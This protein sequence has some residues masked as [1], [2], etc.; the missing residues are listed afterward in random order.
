MNRIFQRTSLALAMGAAMAVTHAQA[1]Q[2]DPEERVE[3]G[4]LNQ[5]LYQQG[6][7]RGEN[8]LGAEVFG[9]T[10][11]EIGNVKNVIVSEQNRIVSVIAEVGGFWDMGDTHISVPW[12]K[13]EVTADGVRMPVNE[14]NA[15]DYNLFEGESP[16][17]KQV[18]DQTVEL[19]E[20]DVTAGQRTWKLTELL[21]DYANLQGGAGY[22]YV[23]D[24]LFS[25][26]GEV[27]AV[28]V[29]AANGGPNVRGPYAYPFYGYERGWSPGASSYEVPYSLEDVKKVPQFKEEDYSGLWE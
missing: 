28:I 21:N 8:L 4:E 29:N 18:L 26:Q 14:D 1:Q 20:E 24:V 11:E 5:Q 12:E 10:G 9:E 6:G 13:V 19:G 15:E 27:Q 16:V 25:K 7:I 2:N 22:G 23:N 3:P 17:S